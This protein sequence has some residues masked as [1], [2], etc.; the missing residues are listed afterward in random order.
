MTEERFDSILAKQMPDRE[1]RRRAH[2]LVDTG[3]GF[4]AAEQQV[5]DILRSLAGRPGG[6]GRYYKHLERDR[7]FGDGRS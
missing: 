2:F 6:A 7:R 5:R 3:R 4:P 1:K